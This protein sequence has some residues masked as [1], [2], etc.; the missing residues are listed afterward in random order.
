MQVSILAADTCIDV[1]GN[2]AADKLDS[3]QGVMRNVISILTLT[4][5]MTGCQYDPYAGKYTVVEP[6]ENDVIGTYEYDFQTIDYTV[7][8]EGIEKSG[9]KIII[10]SDKTYKIEKIPYFKKVGIMRYKFEKQISISGTWTIQEI[11]A[12]DFGNGNIKKHWG[13]I[14][15]SAPDELK[16]AGL[17]GPEKPDGIV[18]GFGDPDS[19]EV[20]TL[21]RK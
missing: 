5:I 16:Y 11:G 6:T 18:F 21:N 8:K 14:L 12:V 9:P 7:D 3:L 10:N 17:M 15:E 1:G 19:G 20:M 4:T 2:A 13:L